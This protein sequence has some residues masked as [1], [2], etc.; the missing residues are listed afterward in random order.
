[1]TSGSTTAFTYTLHKETPLEAVHRNYASCSSTATVQ[2]HTERT[3][4][5]MPS[6]LYGIDVVP[7]PAEAMP[8]QLKLCTKHAHALHDI[9]AVFLTSRI[10]SL[11]TPTLWLAREAPKQP[12]H[13]EISHLKAQ[14]SAEKQASRLKDQLLASK[15]QLLA[16]NEALAALSAENM[17]VKT[18]QL[19]QCSVNETENT[20]ARQ[21]RRHGVASF[22]SCEGASPLDNDE[23]LDQIFSYVGGGDHLYVAAVSRRWRGRYMQYCAQSKSSGQD[24][25]FVTRHRSTIITESRL[26]HAKFN[27]FC[28]KERFDLTEEDYARLIC[29]HSVEPEQVI[30]VLRVHGVPWGDAICSAAAYCNR[31]SLLK[32]LHCNDC[33]WDE[34]D[35]LKEASSSGSVPMLQWLVSVTK[36]WSQSTKTA[37]LDIAASF[38]K[39]SAAKWLR[40]NGAAWP[41]AFATEHDYY[42]TTKE[43][44][45][46]SAVQCAMACGSGWLD[47]KCQD[48]AANKWRH[49]MQ[50]TDCMITLAAVVQSKCRKRTLR[51]MTSVLYGADTGA[52]TS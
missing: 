47:W 12:L 16:K 27:G 15:D 14:L 36:P 52:T 34:L 9:P 48:Y 26:L 4:A 30:T 21:H 3:S 41:N 2:Q 46:L 45:S 6:V 50:C 10:H 22:R 44:W 24:K 23:I 19:Q 11:S 28:I 25:K 43:C 51:T 35:V 33:E 49:Y 18:K 7:L 38:D 39:L 29:K 20:A 42:R 37:M 1:M 17:A 40:A 13:A 5:T 31:L 8:H 32:W